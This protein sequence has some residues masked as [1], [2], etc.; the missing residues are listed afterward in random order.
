MLYPACGRLG[1]SLWAAGGLPEKPRKP[2]AACE[3]DGSDG[4]MQS[5]TCVARRL[6][7][8]KNC[9]RVHSCRLLDDFK[10]LSDAGR[11]RAGLRTLLPP[12][13]F[14]I[15]AS[16]RAVV[17][18]VE[19]SRQV[20]IW[21]CYCAQPS[22]GHHALPDFPTGS[23]AGQYRHRDRGGKAKGLVGRVA[24]SGLGRTSRQRQERFSMT[25]T[26]C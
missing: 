11:R 1:G 5:W 7:P 22:P 18:A 2:N 6:P 23:F 24:V 3:P 26:M 19:G 4:L 17:A 15:A 20:P 13:G 14:E 16:R 12:D 10:R 25:A 21:P 8:A 9:W